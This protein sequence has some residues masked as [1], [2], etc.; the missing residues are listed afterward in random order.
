MAPDND[1]YEV[2]WVE[3]NMEK[4]ENYSWNYL[5]H[6]VST[7]G[8][9][10]FVLAENLKYWRFRLYVLPL[11]PFIPF[12]NQIKESPTVCRCDIYKKPTA[13]EYVNL[14]FV[15][16]CLNKIKRPNSLT[17]DIYRRK[18]RCATMAV[19]DLK[20]PGPIRGLFR[21]RVGS[22]SHGHTRPVLERARDRV[23]ST[24]RPCQCSHREEEDREWQCSHCQEGASHE[25]TAPPGADHQHP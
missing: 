24:V 1:T 13:E 5:D 25:A 8:D 17:T 18:S 19:G 7:R 12:T 22:S 11:K 16:T 21:E 20:P 10:D 3:F 14:R 9:Q 6:Y 4:L 2:S 23:V 15:E